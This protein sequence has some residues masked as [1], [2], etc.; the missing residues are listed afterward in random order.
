METGLEAVASKN[1]WSRCGPTRYYAY[2]TLFVF[3]Q[4]LNHRSHQ[5]QGV[6]CC[7]RR[8]IFRN[9]LIEWKTVGDIP[10]K[11]D[12]FADGDQEEC[13]REFARLHKDQLPENTVFAAK[14]SDNRV[15]E[16]MDLIRGKQLGGG[17][18]FN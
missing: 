18:F 11:S 9:V 16:C 7:H 2:D 12:F 5:W 3:C 13:R 8:Q 4:L 17:H 10:G 15:S 6:I 1:S 14:A